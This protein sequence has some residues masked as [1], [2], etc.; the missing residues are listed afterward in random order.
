[1]M[2]AIAIISNSDMHAHRYPF[3]LA[4]FVYPLEFM[5]VQ[6]TR[7]YIL[8]SPSSNTK[9]SI[10]CIFSSLHF[11]FENMLVHREPSWYFWNRMTLL[12]SKSHSIHPQKVQGSL[13]FNMFTSMQP[14]PSLILKQI[15]HFCHSWKQ[16]LK[17]QLPVSHLPSPAPCPQLQA[18]TN[19][20]FFLYRFV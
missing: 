12:R 10:I 17:S 8:F 13:I 15:K 7:A 9:R 4:L 16:P 11:S 6:A 20:H 1:M 14:S 2:F 19:L 18:M 5:Q 3:S